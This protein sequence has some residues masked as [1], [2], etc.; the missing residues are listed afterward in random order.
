MYKLPV[1]KNLPPFL[2]ILIINKMLKVGLQGFNLKDFYR[3]V[4]VFNYD[5]GKLN[6]RYIKNGIKICPVVIQG[7]NIQQLFMPVG[8]KY[9]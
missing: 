9:Q 7:L 5:Y 6:F 3:Q 2:C 1:P 4:L 8:L